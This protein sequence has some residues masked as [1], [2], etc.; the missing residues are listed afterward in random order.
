MPSP[1]DILDRKSRQRL[2]WESRRKEVGRKAIADSFDPVTGKWTVREGSNIY[3]TGCT[4][5]TN[6]TIKVGQEVVRKGDL[7]DTMRK[8]K[9][10]KVQQITKGRSQNIKY[11]L[12]KTINGVISLWVCGHQDECVKVCDLPSGSGFGSEVCLN[13]LGGDEFLLSFSV[14]PGNSIPNEVLPWTF[15]LYSQD[16]LVSQY[17]E[18]SLRSFLPVPFATW[19]A[20]FFGSTF[21]DIAFGNWFFYPVGYGKFIANYC[22][23]SGT[24]ID[25]LPGGRPSSASG[26]GYI[27]ALLDLGKTPVEIRKFVHP[28]IFGTRGGTEGV[29]GP[30][31]IIWTGLQVFSAWDR[32]T[33]SDISSTTTYG[34]TAFSGFS[35]T[36]YVYKTSPSG[37]VGVG[38]TFVEGMPAGSNTQGYSFVS[39]DAGEVL[40]RGSYSVGDVLPNEVPGNRFSSSFT[41]FPYDS[42]FPFV[43][44]T[45]DGFNY[46]ETFPASSS[47]IPPIPSTTLYRIERAQDIKEVTVQQLGLDFTVQGSIEVEV[48]PPDINAGATSNFG[49]VLCASFG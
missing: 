10:K 35:S 18:P 34:P 16:G 27:R 30:D 33:S 41:V 24:S 25:P 4:P 13:N 32:L 44:A 15:Y 40:F 47:A 20:A 14:T 31:S 39:T 22:S 36:R 23:D 38:E 49:T 7:I 37:D 3:F 8:P 28:S 42:Y 9:G 29:P 5:I 1:F 2:E 46:I 26:R 45:E 48:F 21:F 19:P 6:G 17:T 11:V 12:Q 43:D